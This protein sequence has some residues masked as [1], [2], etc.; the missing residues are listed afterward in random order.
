MGE[1]LDMF[2]NSGLVV[3]DLRTTLPTNPNNP[4]N[5]RELDQI[6]GIVVHHTAGTYDD[7]KAKNLAKFHIRLGYQGIAY[8][9][10][11]HPNG[12][13]DFCHRLRD[14]GPQ[15]G[16]EWNRITFGICCAGNYVSKEPT[17][18]M[19]ESLV[20][21]VEVLQEFFPTRVFVIPHFSVAQT[22]CP[23]KIWKLYE[24]NKT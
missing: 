16:G 10:L 22:A 12:E 4:W 1:L 14:W 13:I 6:F 7:Y 21:L 20:K 24:E 23:G 2:A 3:H 19:V 5:Y 9:F 15:A 18:V 11:I 8:T 17:A